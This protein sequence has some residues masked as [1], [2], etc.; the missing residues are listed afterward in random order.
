MQYLYA[1]WI[2]EIYVNNDPPNIYYNYASRDSQ[3]SEKQYE[4]SRY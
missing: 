1:D 3:D 4:R 2:H